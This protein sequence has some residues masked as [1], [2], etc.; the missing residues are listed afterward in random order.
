MP[1]CRIPPSGLGISTRPMGCGT[2]LPASSAAHIAGQCSSRQVGNSATLTP[3]TPALLSLALTGFRARHMPGVREVGAGLR[4]GPMLREQ[5]FSITSTGCRGISGPQRQ[6]TFAPPAPP[7]PVQGC[8]WAGG[9]SRSSARCREE[10]GPLAAK[11]DYGCELTCPFAV[12]QPS[13]FISHP[14]GIRCP[15]SHS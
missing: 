6:A 7:R 5:P 8:C 12:A 14:G 11:P 15:R 2:Q 1:D 10:S 4:S 3:S 9:D 13:T